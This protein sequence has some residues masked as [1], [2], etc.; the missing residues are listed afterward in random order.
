MS[1]DSPFDRQNRP[2]KPVNVPM[3]QRPQRIGLRD[4][5]VVPRVGSRMLTT[6][7]RRSPLKG[8]GPKGYVRS[9]EHVR[10]ALEEALAVDPTLDPSDV[11]VA[12]T[13]GVVTLSGSV[14][15]WRTRHAVRA[16]AE[17]I[18]GP[19]GVKDAL[20]VADE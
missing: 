12:V 5:P 14:A 13:D 4:E 2:S 18:A 3:V 7:E 17:A 8:R 9:D 19:G 16:I 15:G 10:H 6:T 11:T 20:T 1:D